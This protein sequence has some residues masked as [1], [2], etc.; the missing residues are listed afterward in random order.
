MV[1]DIDINSE[2]IRCCGHFRFDVWGFYR[3]LF[4]RNYFCSFRYEGLKSVSK[5]IVDKYKKR[6]K[7]NKNQE[8]N[9]SDMTS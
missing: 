2:A 8:I 1:S 6:N 4:I 5:L 3:T 9:I 7:D